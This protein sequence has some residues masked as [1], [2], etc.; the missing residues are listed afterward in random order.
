MASSS[1]SHFWQGCRAEP[2][3]VKTKETNP[4]D[5]E[6]RS[7]CTAHPSVSVP[8]V[9]TLGEARAL[10]SQ[11]GS[12]KGGGKGSE[13]IFEARSLHLHQGLP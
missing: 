7:C 11:E 13:Y 2:I 9:P 1:F 5:D 12:E 6:R 8:C 4:G 3:P 10:P